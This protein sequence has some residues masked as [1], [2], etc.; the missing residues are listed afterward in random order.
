M[1]VLVKR[2]DLHVANTFICL[3]CRKEGQYWI[4]RSEPRQIN[5]YEF[6]N[7]WQCLE[8]ATGQGIE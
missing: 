7:D 6:I 2:P 4:V 5:H 1:K 3:T 8:C